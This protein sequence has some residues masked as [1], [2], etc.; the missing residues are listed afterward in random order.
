MSFDCTWA[1]LA[2]VVVVG[3]NKLETVSDKAVVVVH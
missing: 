2:V 3:V 1:A